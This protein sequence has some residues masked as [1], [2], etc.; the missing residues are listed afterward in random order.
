MTTVTEAATVGV[1]ATSW[2]AP[3]EIALPSGGTASRARAM[4]TSSAASTMDLESYLT[5]YTGVTR[6][7]RLAFVASASP[8]LKA[9]A[10]DSRWTG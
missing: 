4:A 5:N 6:L 7:K 2:L 9:E 1:A 3:A 10:L 8:A